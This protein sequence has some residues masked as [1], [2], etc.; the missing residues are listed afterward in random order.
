MS[1]DAALAAFVAAWQDYRSLGEDADVGARILMK[2]IAESVYTRLLTGSVDDHA[3]GDADL[4]LRRQL[5]KMTVGLPLAEFIA[6]GDSICE[7]IQRV[8]PAIDTSPKSEP[9]GDFI[10]RMRSLVV[11]H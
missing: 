4:A 5:L 6:T 3:S 1:P 2:A 10:Q 8:H 7:D 9:P 11:R